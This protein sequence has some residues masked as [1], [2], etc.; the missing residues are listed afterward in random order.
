MATA[1]QI[2]ANQKNSQKSTGPK[3][4]TGKASS[5]RNATKHGL[6][7]VD[8]IVNSPYLKEDPAE[9]DAL[10]AGL[11]DDLK[12]Q[13]AF[14][15]QLV[16]KIAT[17]L[18]RQRRAINAE[19]A[20]INR[21][22]R[23]NNLFPSYDYPDLEEEDVE[24]T[25]ELLDRVH[26]KAAPYSNFS[27]SLMQYE[28]RLERQL[29]NTL[30]VYHSLKREKTRE[31]QR[32]EAKSRTETRPPTQPPP[33]SSPPE[34]IANDPVALE[35]WQNE[36]NYWD[37]KFPPPFTQPEGGDAPSAGSCPADGGM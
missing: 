12:P 21:Q 9:Y 35:K 20:W 15:Q 33:P 19:T 5:S 36:A 17:C 7:A 10:V 25:Q 31:N 30:K 11:I 26:I 13:G 14:Q 32:N 27:D 22:L 2:R 6:Y 23:H 24:I 37:A 34:S 29:Q 18:W 3:T 4:E 16:V 8:I 28:H 1:K